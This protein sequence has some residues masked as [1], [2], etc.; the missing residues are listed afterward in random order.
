MVFTNFPLIV[1]ETNTN[2]RVLLPVIRYI[3]DDAT[4]LKDFYSQKNRII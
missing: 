1:P 3:V 2:T 4:K